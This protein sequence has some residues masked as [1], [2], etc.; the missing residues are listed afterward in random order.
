MHCR[1]G[2]RNGIMLEEN[3]CITI[4]DNNVNQA[5]LENK[6]IINLSNWMR[7]FTYNMIYIIAIGNHLTQ[8]QN[9]L[10]G[11]NDHETESSSIIKSIQEGIIEELRNDLL[12]SFIIANTDRNMNKGK[13]VE[14]LQIYSALL[15][16]SH[17]PEVS[18]KNFQDDRTRNI[19]LK[20]LDNLKYCESII[21]EVSRLQ[22][23]IPSNICL[24]SEDDEIAISKHSVAWNEPLKFNPDR[25]YNYITNVKTIDV[26][27]HDVR[28]QKYDVEFVDMN[29]PLKPNLLSLQLVL[30]YY[31]D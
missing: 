7:R 13:C 8:I 5:L 19:T 16:I 25:F 15:F 12:T 14:Q 22:S 21:K 31:L 11:L 6:E 30:S 23:I 4:D 26:N 20:R 2:R 1:V 24:N 18:V 9:Y 28:K 29:A 3:W 27:E 17:H 10:C